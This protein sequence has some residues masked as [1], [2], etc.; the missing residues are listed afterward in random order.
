MFIIDVDLCP[1]QGG[2]AQQNKRYSRFHEAEWLRSETM[3]KT[4][5]HHL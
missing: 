2:V 4:N 1:I 5:G 3:A